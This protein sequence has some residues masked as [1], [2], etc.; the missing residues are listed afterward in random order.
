MGADVMRW[1]FCEIPPAQNLKFG[2]G[3]AHEVK[4]RLLTLWN[5]VSF[6]VTYANIEEFTPD[7]RRPRPT[8]SRVGGSPSQPLDAWLVQR[9]RQLVEEATKAYEE[10]WTPAVTRAF[11]AFVDD[12]SNW[13]IRRSRRR[14]YSFDEAAFRTLWFALAQSLRVIAPVIPFEADH[15]WRNL[16]AG[17][18]EG[19]PDSVHLAGWPEVEEADAKLLAEIA[20]VR[21]IVELGRQARSQAGIKQRQPL[22]AAVVYGASNGTREHADEIASELRVR[23]VVLAEGG[24]SKLRLKPNLPVLGPRLGPKLPELRRALEAGEW[25]WED[26][27]VRVAGELLEE[28]EVIVEREA[29]N[30]GFTFASDGTVSVEID[31]ALDDD[32]RLEGRFYDLVHAVNA[33]R[34]DRGLEVTDRIRLTLPRAEADVVER[35]AR[36]AEGRDARR[37]PRGRRRA[38]PRALLDRCFDP[39]EEIAEHGAVAL[40]L[41]DERNVRAVVEDGVLGAG[42]PLDHRL[43][44]LL[45]ARVVSAAQHQR[46]HVELAEPVANVPA[47]EDARARPL[48]RA[49][50]RVVD[51]AVSFRLPLLE[52]RRR[53]VEPAHVCGVV[54]LDRRAWPERREQSRG[55][56]RPLGRAR[57]RRRENQ[58]ADAAGPAEC[59]LLREDP[60]PRLPEEVDP[61]EAE[62]LA[63]RADLV[64]KQLERPLDVVGPVGLPAAELV[65]DDDLAAGQLLERVEVRGRGAWAAVQAEERQRA[66]SGARR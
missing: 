21:R 54:V 9:T 18:C 1:L 37:R 48:V 13:Y 62:L 35:Y 63:D 27:K 51:V 25:E 42:D 43:R 57:E 47:G 14:F 58:R 16:V 20:E 64:E 8:A 36:P 26:G 60:A 23:E 50:H 10:Y 53:G 2:Y 55:G 19:A 5:S 6:F 59:V 15:L 11:E 61:V 41:F 56:L 4:R 7:V 22:R 38:R 3:P 52:L 31:P 40:G 66:G 49:P 24:G 33:L 46:R 45:R 39:L 28:R 34:K 30:E 17:V 12:L 29:E 65:V 32:L 44:D